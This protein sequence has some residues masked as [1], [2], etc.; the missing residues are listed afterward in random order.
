VFFVNAATFAAVLVALA[1]IRNH[2]RYVRNVG[3]ATVRLRDGLAYVWHEPTLRLAMG[4]MT[5]VGLFAYNFA[6]IVPSMIRFEFGASA[7]ALGVVQAVGGIGSVLGGLAAGSIRWP[8]TRLLGLVATAFG[9]CILLTAFAP[10]VAVFAVLWLPLGVA[11]AVFTTVDQTVLQRESAPQFQGRVMSLFTIAWMGT[12]PIGGLIAGAVIDHWS[13]R[14]ALGVGA[15]AAL[16]CGAV[17][18]ALGRRIVV[19]GAGAAR[20]PALVAAEL[21]ADLAAGT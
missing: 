4:V 1:V 7:L 17:A 13:A 11:S 2:E 20:G 19:H 5:V 21:E 18:L 15:T 8:T 14:V 16:V 6:I 9:A 12:T 10:G 3:A